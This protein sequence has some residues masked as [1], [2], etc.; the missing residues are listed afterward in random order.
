MTAKDFTPNVITIGVV[1]S[2][3]AKSAKVS[4]PNGYIGTLV[5]DDLLDE[6]IVRF[7]L[8]IMTCITDWQL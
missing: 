1:L 5:F 7:C 3:N 2:V 4:L 8:E 6:P